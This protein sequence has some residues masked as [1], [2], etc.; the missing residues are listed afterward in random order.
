MADYNYPILAGNLNLTGTLTRHVVASKSTL[1]N[2]GLTGTLTRHI[3]AGKGVSGNLG[4]SG[5]VTKRKFYLRSPS[6]NLGLGGSIDA[7]VIHNPYHGYKNLSGIL[8]LSGSVTKRKFYLRS[9]SGNL[10]LSGAVTKRQV[11]HRPTDG[12]LSMYGNIWHGTS[13]TRN[14]FGTALL[15]GSLG[16]I[17]WKY[18][19]GKLATS[20]TLTRTVHRYRGVG[21]TL[22]TS[23]N[24]GAKV[25]YMELDGTLT[26]TGTLAKHIYKMLGGSLGVTGG[27]TGGKTK[28]LGG[29]LFFGRVGN[30]ILSGTLTKLITKS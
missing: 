24:I 27:I 1:G 14:N 2:L 22:G 20:G 16:K 6:G 10:G 23:G 21:G 7:V 5:S 29:S 17:V 4:L 13:G 30:L 26:L 9:P 8:G 12:T 25:P 15:G 19:A 28:M 18:P 3:V 11:L